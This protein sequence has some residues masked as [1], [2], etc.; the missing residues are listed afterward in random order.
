MGNFPDTTRKLK[1]ML[2]A[3]DYIL[4]MHWILKKT[5]KRLIFFY[6]Y[7]C[8]KRKTLRKNGS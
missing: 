5:L 7:S 8:Q 4:T 2:W 6:L 3:I 1:F